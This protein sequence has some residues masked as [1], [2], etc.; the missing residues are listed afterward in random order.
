MRVASARDVATPHPM[1]SGRCS[2]SPAACRPLPARVERCQGTQALRNLSPRAGRGRIALAIRV[3][4]HFPKGDRDCL[5]NARHVAE[6]VVIPEPQYPTVAIDEPLV[7]NHITWTVEVLSSIYFND[8]MTFAT[9]KI[10]R[11][12][13][14][15][16]LS[17]KFAVIEAPRPQSM[18]QRSL[19]ISGTTPQAPSALGPDFLSFPHVETPPHPDCT[20]R[21]VRIAGAI[22]PLPARGERLTSRTI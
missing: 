8:Q 4:G 7:A 15:R 6:H 13:A 9:D 10:D 16:L 3:R 1:R 22:R 11:V 19:G 2:A 21:C 14:N 12:R 5:K 18:P 17:N 20:G